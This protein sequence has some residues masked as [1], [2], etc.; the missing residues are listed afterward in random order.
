MNTPRIDALNHANHVRSLYLVAMERYS[1]RKPG[2]PAKA[3]AALREA[4][5][6]IEADALDIEERRAKN[7]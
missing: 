3:A 7:A 5:E 4:A 6:A 2:D 1:L